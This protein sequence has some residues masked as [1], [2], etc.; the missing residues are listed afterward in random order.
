MRHRE[1]EGN[2]G[3]SETSRWTR[4]EDRIGANELVL[5]GAEWDGGMY[6]CGKVER[7]T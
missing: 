5:L 2:L 6:R 4:S 3:H 7:S 1:R